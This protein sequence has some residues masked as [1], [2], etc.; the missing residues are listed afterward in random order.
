MPDPR[1]IRSMFAR[2]SPRYD[3]L[4]RVLSLGID[5]RWRSALLRAAGEVEGRTIVDLCC[6]TGDVSF[7]FAR[8]GARVV[9]I[10]FTLEMVALA[11]RKRLRGRP[12]AGNLLFAHGDATAVPLRGAC[13][14]VATIAFGIRNVHDRAGSLRDV[15]R[16]LVPGGKL[17]VLEF[18]RPGDRRLAGAYDFYFE[19]V[20]PRIGGLLSG[21]REAY[22]YLPRSVAA[23]PGPDA[24]RSE[25]EA[26]GF[27]DCGYRSLS[28]GI[29]FLHWGST[30]P[31]PRNP[32]RTRSARA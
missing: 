31:D 7:L 6:G 4:N 26:A 11:E 23:W 3:F 14:D 8:H 2:I 22:A 1:E 32:A 16:V 30:P 5:R 10:D 28:G 19:R 12:G 13:A 20:L 21:D 9:G 29:A 18:G 17:L 15:A 25:I 24:F 27:V